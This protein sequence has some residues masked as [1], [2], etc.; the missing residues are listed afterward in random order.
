MR[1]TLILIGYWPPVKQRGL[2]MKLQRLGGFD[3]PRASI[4]QYAT[5]A[6]IAADILYTA[7]AFGD[8]QD[9][10]IIDLGCGTG[11]FSIG[12]CLLDAGEVYG[13]DIDPDAVDIARKNAVSTGCDIEF[14]SFPVDKVSGNWNTCIMNPPFGSQTKHAD[15]P[16][17]DRA[18]DVA[19]VIYSIHNSGTLPFLRQRIEKAGHIPDLEKNYKFEI[20]HTFEFHRKDKMNIDVTLLRIVRQ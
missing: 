15:L 18:M 19:D 17:L 1:K 5:P 11:V 16:F 20:P 10:H 6:G 7:H 9:R 4:E 3:N 14:Q 2:E 8:I 12:A 13:I